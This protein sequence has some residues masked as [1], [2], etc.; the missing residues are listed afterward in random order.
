[1]AAWFLY[2]NWGSLKVGFAPDDMMNLAYFWR[3]D[4]WH[5]VAAQFA[6]WAGPYRP[7]AAAFYLPLFAIFRFNP[8]PYHAVMMLVL[9]A[10]CW[11]AYRFARALGC[12]PAV[13]GMVALLVAYH[14]GLKD[15]YFNTRLHL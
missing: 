3:A 15:L 13:S 8:L 6:L 12:E 2:F 7:L 4:P 14:P 5:W 1:M 10:N 9:A 11:L